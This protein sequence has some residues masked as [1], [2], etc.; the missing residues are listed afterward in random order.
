[1]LCE[2]LVPIIKEFAADCVVFGGG[3]SKS[4]QLFSDGIKKEFLSIPC[5]KRVAVTSLWE[6]AAIAGVASVFWTD[7]ESHY[8]V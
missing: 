5:M 3:M 7:F 1:M 4:F 8:E 2:I 6:L